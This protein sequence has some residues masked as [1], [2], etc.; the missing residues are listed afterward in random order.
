MENTSI[1]NCTGGVFR[2]I[3]ARALGAQ[4]RHVNFAKTCFT[5]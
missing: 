5:R 4:P 3:T 2:K 1:Y